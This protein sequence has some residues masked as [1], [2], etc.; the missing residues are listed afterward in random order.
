VSKSTE[1][2][3]KMLRYTEADLSIRHIWRDTHAFRLHL[4][5]SRVKTLCL[6]CFYIV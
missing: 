3:I 2:K 5:F 6:F 1:E 4:T